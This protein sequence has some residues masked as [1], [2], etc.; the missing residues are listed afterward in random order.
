MFVTSDIQKQNRNFISDSRKSDDHPGIARYPILDSAQLLHRSFGNG[1][2]QAV[3]NSNQINGT[4][5]ALTGERRIQRAC[6][7]GGTCGDCNDKEDEL[8]TIQTKLTISQPGDIYEQEANRV[9]EQIMRMPDSFERAQNDH[10]PAETNIQRIGNNSSST[11]ESTS[12]IQ[13]SESGGQS[14]S[15]STRQFMEPRFG[16]DFGHVRLHSDNHAHRTASQIHARAFTYGNH[17]WLGKGESEQN[18]SLIAHELVH[19]VQQRGGL[20]EHANSSNAIGTLK[21]ANIVQRAVSRELDKIESYLSYGLFD[22]AI[23]DED[24]IKALELLKTLPRYQQAV[25]FADIKYVTRLRKNLPSGRVQELNELESA[26]GPIKAPAPK[27]EDIREKLSYGLFDWVITD[28]EAVD[29]LEMLKQLSGTQL[30]VALGSINYG[31]LM[32]NLPDSRKP[33]LMDLL[34]RGLG[35]GG[36]KETEEKEFPGNVLNGITFKSDHGFM[37][38]N[39]TDWENTGTLYGQPEWFVANGKVFSHPVSQN[40]NTNIAID[41]K[42]SALPITAPLAPVRLTGKSDEAFLSFD[43]SGM[44]Q[45]GLNQTVSMLSSGKLPDQITTISNKTISWTMEWR[46]W[47]HEIGRTGPHTIFVTMDTPLKPGE[48]THKR[49]A[50]AANLAGAIGTLDPH[51]LVR[52]IMQRWGAYNLKVQLTNAWTLADNLDRGAQCIDIV[53]FVGGLLEMVGCPGT[54]T[55]VVVWAKPSTPMTEEEKIWPHGGLHTIGHHPAHSD[56]FVALMDANGC[57]NAYEAALKFEHNGTLRYYPG[58]VPMDKE[59]KTPLDVL[60][61]FQCLAW[62]TQVGSDS[63]EIQSILATYPH[64]SCTTGPI[65]CND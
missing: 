47:K 65:S 20:G 11:L 15:L 43:F 29:A 34:A 46:N 3:G 2:L 45:G 18:Q 38:D 39:T 37:K 31:R 58:G 13:L 53:R 55:A 12:D 50:L 54:A 36:A 24:A 8:Q 49:M 51:L 21:H 10:P 16:T 64:G 4:S 6:A 59:Y 40:R 27:V 63:F 7:C 62:L 30:A 1:Y 23:T 25:F 56:W 32:D 9:A 17:I 60:H 57:P 14:L 26:V 44:M 61:V 28:K 19:V 42:L 35:I 41:A 5:N 22:W 48:V 52:G 33:E